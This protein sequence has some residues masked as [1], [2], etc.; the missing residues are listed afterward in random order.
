MVPNRFQGQEKDLNKDSRPPWTERRK[1]P[2]LNLSLEQFKLQGNGKIFSVVDLSSMGMGVRV[3]DKQD[4]AFFP[5]GRRFEG[6][7]NLRRKKHS[8]V[9]VVK[10]VYPDRIGCQFRE[11][12]EATQN[13]L[14]DY[15][16]PMKLGAGLRPL[17]ASVEGGGVWY[18]GPSDTEFFIWR[19]LDG[20]YKRF[21]LLVLGTFVRW[22]SPGTLITGRVDKHFSPGE[23]QGV[24]RLD[25]LSLVTDKIIDISKLELAKTL[26]MCSELP[27]DLQSW[28]TRCLARG[29]C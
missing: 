6:L 5:V 10:N 20:Q 24:F 23:V 7:L 8:I 16:D 29:S 9:A 19:A 22:D 1:F 13:A 27:L 28:C 21:F 17:P 18:H 11:L 15:L 14:T 4:L 3:I 25:T 2:R 26:I 12:T